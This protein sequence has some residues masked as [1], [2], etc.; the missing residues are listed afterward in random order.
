MPNLKPGQWSRKFSECEYCHTTNYEH[1]CYGYCFKCRDNHPKR[2]IISAN[3]LKRYQQ[4]EAYR[5]SLAK[6]RASEK[7]QDWKKRWLFQLRASKPV[8][9]TKMGEAGFGGINV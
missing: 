1:W 7:Y 4:T 3:R 2:K 8:V 5:K 9:E 6:Y